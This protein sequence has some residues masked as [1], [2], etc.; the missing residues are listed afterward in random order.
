MAIASAAKSAQTTRISR[1][2]AIVA[3]VPSW[4]DLGYTGGF[5]GLSPAF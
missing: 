2:G 1:A 4:A 5:A 3:I